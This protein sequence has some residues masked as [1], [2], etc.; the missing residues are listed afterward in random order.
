[1][2]YLGKR[3]EENLMVIFDQR[4]NLYLCLNVEAD[5]KILNGI[6]NTSDISYQV[7][8]KGNLEPVMCLA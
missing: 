7:P 5:I 3:Y 6:Y 8:Q 1:M 4:L 2:P